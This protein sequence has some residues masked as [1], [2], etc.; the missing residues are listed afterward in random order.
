MNERKKLKKELGKKY[1]FKKFMTAGQVRK[2]FALKNQRLEKIFAAL[3]VGNVRIN[4]LVFVSHGKTGTVCDIFVR[5]IPTSEQWICYDT[6][7]NG[8]RYSVFNT[9]QELFNILNKEVEKYGLSY[10]ECNFEILEGKELKAVSS[11]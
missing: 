6:I 10:T 7:Q 3:T 2:L 8:F 1:I 11:R 4:A 5:D 9:E